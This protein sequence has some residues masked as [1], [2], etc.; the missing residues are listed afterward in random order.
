MARIL[1]GT[2]IEFDAAITAAAD[3]LFNVLKDDA[4]GSTIKRGGY[5]YQ[6]FTFSAND[7]GK[8]QI[9]RLEMSRSQF[10]SAEVATKAVA[11]HC[12][13]SIIYGR[14]SQNAKLSYFNEI[15]FVIN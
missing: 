10:T 1:K 4:P 14:M 2:T 11:L 7:N 12:I 8:P 3:A 6:D 15:K 5:L 9:L 13:R